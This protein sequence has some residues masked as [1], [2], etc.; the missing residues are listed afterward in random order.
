MNKNNKL[1]ITEQQKIMCE[2][3]GVLPQ[4]PEEMVAIALDNLNGK[5]IY[6]TRIKR[7]EGD[8]ISWFFYCEEYCEQ[9]DFYQSLHTEHLEEVLPEVINYLYL[10]EGYNFI[11]DR[12][13]YEDVWF[14]EISE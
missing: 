8:T 10:P 12:D 7:S 1:F 9:D 14:E 5:P 4:K 3:Y 11:I 6:G 2:R 13:G